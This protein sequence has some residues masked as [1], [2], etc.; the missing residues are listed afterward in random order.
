MPTRSVSRSF[1]ATSLLASGRVK[2]SFTNCLGLR[3]ELADDVGVGAAAREGDQA[4]VVGRLEPGRA[5]PDPVLLLGLGEGVE[6]EHR[7]PLR[8]RLAVL[9]ERR[10][11][12]QPALVLLVAP[13][14]VVEL[15]A[16]RD[17]G[18]LL[19][20][21]EDLEQA[22]V[23]RLELRPLGQFG[24]GL[25]VALLDPRERLL[26]GHVFEPQEWVLLPIGRGG[27]RNGEQDR[28]QEHEPEVHGNPP[29]EFCETIAPGRC[30]VPLMSAA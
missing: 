14:V 17:V 9:V 25:R 5:V 21:I 23:E 27:H 10:A 24:G 16:L 1:Q 22:V 19:L 4:P 20:R 28:G 12:P 7:L 30:C 3:V 29:G 8:L 6:V 2:P 26:A 13:E 15:A 11:P 18:D